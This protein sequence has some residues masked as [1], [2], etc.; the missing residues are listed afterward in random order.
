MTAAARSR[1]SAPPERFGK[2][3]VSLAPHHAHYRSFGNEQIE[4]SRCSLMHMQAI[5]PC[6]VGRFGAHPKQQIENN[7]GDDGAGDQRGHGY[8]IDGAFVVACAL[9]TAMLIVMAL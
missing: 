7:N 6:R 2:E 5:P 1:P 8:I 9:T 3:T 4:P